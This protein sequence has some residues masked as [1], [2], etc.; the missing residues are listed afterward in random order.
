MLEPRITSSAKIHGFLRIMESCSASKQSMI[1]SDYSQLYP[2]VGL[3]YQTDGGPL[4]TLFITDTEVAYFQGGLVFFVTASEFIQLAK[5]RST[6]RSNSLALTP[7][8]QRR[9]TGMEV[10]FILGVISVVDSLACWTILGSDLPGFFK[11]KRKDLNRWAIRITSLLLAQTLL[12]KYTGRLYD[13]VSSVLVDGVW[14][15]VPESASTD[16]ASIA[17]LTGYLLGYYG[18]EEAMEKAIDLRWSVFSFILQAVE[19][20]LDK[21]RAKGEAPG[22]RLEIRVRDLVRSFRTLGAH[23]AVDE[24]HSMLKEIERHPNEI[25]KAIELLRNPFE[26]GNSL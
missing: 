13:K 11:L 7:L 18:S 5:A 25:K 17:R 26:D 1:E 14:S 24:V 4:T 16:D 6:H 10:E 23:I 15:K 2:K 22:R 3:T 21:S 12:K 8:N 20:V 9:L 19:S